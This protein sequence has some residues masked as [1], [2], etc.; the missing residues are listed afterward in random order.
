M[1]YVLWHG[2]MAMLNVMSLNKKS[3]QSLENLSA[4]LPT[5][6]DAFLTFTQ[7]TQKLVL[8][9]NIIDII[10][11]NIIAINHNHQLFKI[12]CQKHCYKLKEALLQTQ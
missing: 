11:T 12:T 2:T 8:L 9:Y 4:V 10:T 5:K 6:F 7:N 1:L 3:N